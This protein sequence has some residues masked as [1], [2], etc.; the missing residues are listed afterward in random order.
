MDYAKLIRGVVDTSAIPTALIERIDIVT[1]TASENVFGEDPPVVGNEA[2]STAFNGGNTLPS[3]YDV[4]GSVYS[5]GAN[6]TF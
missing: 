1:E 2:A 3:H 5:V 4:V 6:A